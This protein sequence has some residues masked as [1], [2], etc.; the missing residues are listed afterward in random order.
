MTRRIVVACPDLLFRARIFAAAEA[1]GV[2][3]TSVKP[4]DLPTVEKGALVL[5]DLEVP[6]VVPHAAAAVAAGARV[7]GFGS[8]K[9]VARLAAARQAGIDAMP[10]SAFVERLAALVN[11]A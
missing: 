1:A 9:D 10:R 6:G 7:V 8:H 3:V 11:E 2:A 4:A 5:V